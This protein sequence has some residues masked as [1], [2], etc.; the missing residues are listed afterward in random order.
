[1]AF[2]NSSPY[3]ET[4][5]NTNVSVPRSAFNLSHVHT[6]QAL[7]GALTPVLCMETLPNQDIDLN[8]TA[9]INLRNPTPRK[10]INGC[11]VYFHAYYN[12]CSDLW[13]GFDN[14][15]THGR[16]QDVNLTKPKLIHSLTSAE[17]ESGYAVEAFTPLSLANYFGIPAVAQQIMQNDN[18]TFPPL[19]NFQTAIMSEN[20]TERWKRLGY[21][22]NVDALPFMAYQR[23]WRDFYCNK[24]LLMNNKFWFP[25]NE[26]HF[27]LSY[28][29]T[30]AVCI[31]YGD[32]SLSSNS[33][34]LSNLLGSAAGRNYTTPE[35]NNP[36]T[37]DSAGVRWV[38]PNLCGLKFRQFRGDR[39][40]TASPFA[41]L[42]RGSVPSLSNFLSNSG[43][44]RMTTPGL[45]GGVFVY[46]GNS[47]NISAFSSVR[48]DIWTFNGTKV[49][50]TVSGNSSIVIPP[51]TLNNIRA[52]QTYTVFAERLARTSGDYNDMIQALFG[53][54]PHHSVHEGT[55]VGGCYQDMVFDSVT[56]T[57]ESTTSSPLG[58]K[59][60]QGYSAGNGRIGHFHS[61]DYGWLQVYMSIV[62]EVYYTQGVHRQF[63][64]FNPD[65][66]YNPL[67][68]NLAP[69]AIKNKELYISGTSAT[70]ED[71]FGYEQRA[72]EFRSRTN[73]VS[74]F[75]A[76]SHEVASFDASMVMSRRFSSTPELN[77]KFL[78]MVPEN[79]DMDVFSFND[80]PPFDFSVAFD[81]DTVSPIPRV[82]VPG[83]LSDE[84]HA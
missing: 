50:L 18:V 20:H 29:C 28:G 39:F 68:N 11:R 69:Q 53:F 22:T 82:S 62:P 64:R 61:P 43:A 1:M 9:V 81:L 15:V 14:F 3:Q 10:L 23:N 8:L 19:R 13:E 12:R 54:N 32:E 52:L 16:R 80:E 72:N 77:S 70:D 30:E 83:S 44:I 63:T 46:N 21:A 51:I 26:S 56:Q 17:T 31:N 60:G 57:S 40:T 79:I 58:S 55:Y 48:P 6:G 75:S 65:D 84:L 24:N 59:A 37:S 33:E 2:D 34:R 73:R 42:I 78:T 71:V 38:S 66:M 25:D 4:L 36:S 76:L 47:Y 35:P 5:D 7:I 41:D 49:D 27:I 67:W 45:P 74:G